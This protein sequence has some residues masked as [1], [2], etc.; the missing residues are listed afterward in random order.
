MVNRP[1]L[2]VTLFCVCVVAVILCGVALALAFS[3]PITAAAAIVF[4]AFIV[5]ARGFVLATA[6]HTIVTEL[7]EVRVQAAA[8]VNERVSTL[9]ECV[10]SRQ[11]RQWPR[12][13]RRAA[14]RA[15]G[16]S[17]PLHIGGSSLWMDEHTANTSA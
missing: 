1:R 9:S 12:I 2:L 7:S 6:S 17:R 4:L 5:R 14:P 11:F 13:S 3:T 16:V 15:V 8:R 10:S